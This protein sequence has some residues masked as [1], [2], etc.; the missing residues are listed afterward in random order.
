MIYLAQ[1]GLQCEAN[2]SGLTT[3]V[4]NVE[5]DLSSLTDVVD[6]VKDDISILQ[7]TYAL[8]FEKINLGGTDS[9]SNPSLC[10]AFLIQFGEADMVEW[11]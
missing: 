8:S 3:K 10:R 5:T 6:T 2:L 4:N 11:F 9:P 1:I 7:T